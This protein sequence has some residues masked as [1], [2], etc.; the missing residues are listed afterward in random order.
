MHHVCNVLF[1]FRHFLASAKSTVCL[2]CIKAVGPSPGPSRVAVA[3]AGRVLS[4]SLLGVAIARRLLSVLLAFLCAHACICPARVLVFPPGEVTRR[5]CRSASQDPDHGRPRVSHK[6]CCRTLPFI[7]LPLSGS[8][9]HTRN[10]HRLVASHSCC[11]LVALLLL[12]E[13]ALE[14]AGC[15]F[16]DSGV[17]ICVRCTVFGYEGIASPRGGDCMSVH[18][19]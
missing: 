6:E 12:L 9:F 15:S 3:A 11:C 19:L 5:R 8:A 4:W 2:H 18:S 10:R 14:G 7:I 1:P 13:R 16:F 17:D